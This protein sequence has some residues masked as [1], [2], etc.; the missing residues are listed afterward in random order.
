MSSAETPRAH[1]EQ[2]LGALFATAPE[3][4]HTYLWTIPDKITYWTPVAAGPSVMAAKAVELSSRANV[5]VAVSVADVP[6]PSDRRISNDSSA[7]I[8]GLWA[9]IDIAEPDVHKKFNLP[10]DEASAMELLDSLGLPPTIIVHSGHGLQAW[11]LFKEFWSFNSDSDRLQAAGLAKRWN[12]TIRLRAANHRWVV[13][14]T[15]DLARVMRVPGTLNR[16]TEPHQPVRLVKIIDARYDYDDFPLADADDPAWNDSGITPV[17][18]YQFTDTLVLNPKAYPAAQKLEALQEN[19]PTFRLT[20]ERRRKDMPDQTASSYDLALANAL[21]MAEWSDQEIA[22]AIIAWRTKHN[23]EP[24]KAMRVDY[25]KR[26]IRK[27]REKSIQAGA[28][29]GLAE[30]EEA[31]KVAKESEDPDEI[32]DARRDTWEA[33]GL[34][35]GNIKITR[36]VKYTTSPAQYVIETPKNKINFD[37]IEE[38]TDQT[39]CRNRVMEVLSFADPTLLMHRPVAWAK[40]YSSILRSAE[41]EDL[42]I[43][44]T[45]NGQVSV[46]LSDYLAAKPPNDDKDEALEGNYPWRDSQGTHI[47]SSNFREWI[48]YSAG[49]KIGPKILHRMLRQYGCKNSATPVSLKTGRTSRTTWLLPS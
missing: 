42:G 37:R 27:A 36:I 11:W 23:Q 21:V 6:G 7:G 24:S 15:F 31:L 5:Y 18:E 1:A 47:V 39:K 10:P 16:K 45:P 14:S 20:W 33:I 46:W 3:K 12:D 13:D 30:A 29:E 34:Q 4:A 28:I 40:I 48:Q 49:E 22:D 8:M 38:L 9:D 26:T 32:R 43:E 41:E 17:E 2:F 35:F 44:T 19:E 25:I